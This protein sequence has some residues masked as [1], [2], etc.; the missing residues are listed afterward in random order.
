MPDV[1][2]LLRVIRISLLI[3]LGIM[4]LVLLT[5]NLTSFF[6][7]WEWRFDRDGEACSVWIYHAKIQVDN[8]PQI[9]IAVRGFLRNNPNASDPEIN[10][11]AAKTG[12]GYSSRWILPFITV[13]VGVAPIRCAIKWRR[14][15]T[16]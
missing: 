8:F 6:H 13:V 14:R 7:W 10:A 3:T 15:L 9:D 1:R 4:F 16:N 11:I 12:W 2:N 5:F